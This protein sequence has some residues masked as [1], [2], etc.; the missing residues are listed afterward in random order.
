MLPFLFLSESMSV[1]VTTESR[2]WSFGTS[3]FKP[4]PRM[5]GTFLQK[6]QPL[7]SQRSLSTVDRFPESQSL[8]PQTFQYRIYKKK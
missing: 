6:I 5:L 7:N 1:N 3:G 8:P 2:V 4:L